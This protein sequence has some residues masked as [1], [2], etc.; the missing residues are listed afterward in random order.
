MVTFLPLAQHVAL[1]LLLNQHICTRSW[2]TTMQLAKGE[3]EEEEQ[4]RSR[5]WT[6]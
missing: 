5:R 6:T 3:K 2:D 4:S 1:L